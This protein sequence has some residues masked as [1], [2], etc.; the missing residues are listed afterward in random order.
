MTPLPVIAG[1]GGINPAGRVSFHHAY[2]RTV[3]DVLGE[4][5]AAETYRSLAGIM[6]VEGDAGDH[7]VRKYIRNNTLVRRIGLFDPEE[8][9]FHRSATLTGPSG[10]ELKFV[11]PVRQLP[12]RV[13]ENWTVKELSADAVEV[14]IDNPTE[15][16]LPDRRVSRV[17]SAGQVPTG[18]DPGALYPSRNHPRGLQLTVYGASDAVHSIG[19]DWA[20]LRR[21]VPPDA[22]AVYSGSAMGQLDQNGTGG[23]LQAPMMG[24]RPTSKQAA[25]GLCEM[26]TDFIN[27]YILGSVGSTGAV[28]GACA[29]FLYNLKQGIDDIRSGHRRVAVVGGAEAPITP[30][31]IEGYRTMGALTE[32]E[33]L[34]TLDGTNEVDNRRAC[35]PFSVNAGFTLAE[36]AVYVVLM[37]DEL[38]LD[39]GAEIYGSV[40]DVFV[41]ADGFKKSIPSPGIGNYVT[42]AKAMATARSLIG[43]GGLRERSYIHAHGTGTPQNRVTESEI[44]NE[45]AKTFGITN[46][47]VAAVKAYLGHTLAPASGDQLTS[48]LG[49]WKYGFIPGI[50]TIDHIA[51]DVHASHLTIGSGHI[52]RPPESLD[53]AF[54]NSKGFGGNNATGLA[55]SPNL[56]LK[57]LEKRHGRDELLAHAR[58]NESVREK[59]RDYDQQASYGEATPIYQFGEGV[60]EG[61][62]LDFN[63]ATIQIPGFEQP[64]ELNMPNPFADM[65]D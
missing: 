24:K 16:L 45:L 61:E 43:D 64:I 51:D 30:E 65:T 36:A 25:L 6:K 63:D 15:V 9:L 37:D 40:P 4:Q 5:D 58:R 1:F 22:F 55:L 49:T 13:P 8:I 20:T 59:A 21:L 29:T 18:F 27:A 38:A 33:A 47:P 34:M 44:M 62:D 60:L 23:M 35:R 31:I 2:R 50:A 12:D 28:I 17:T 53:V 7:A 10:N 32:D 11:I 48:A 41:N 3:I 54:I 42:M 46:W 57:M 56:T 26:P 19:I 14:S 52:E 39:L